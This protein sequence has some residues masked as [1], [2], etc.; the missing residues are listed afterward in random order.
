MNLTLFKTKKGKCDACHEAG[1]LEKIIIKGY[2]FFFCSDCICGATGDDPETKRINE[3]FV[4][5]YEHRIKIIKPC[6]N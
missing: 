2:E 5:N 4:K 3:E 6:K 1:E